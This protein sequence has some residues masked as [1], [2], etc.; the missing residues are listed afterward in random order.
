MRNSGGM[1]SSLSGWLWLVLYSFND[2]TVMSDGNGG[3]G[4]GGGVHGGGG[5]RDAGPQEPQTLGC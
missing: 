3:S 2:C 1:I 4:G 5:A